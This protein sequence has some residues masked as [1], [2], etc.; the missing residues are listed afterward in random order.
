MRNSYRMS[1]E[2]KASNCDSRRCCCE[3]CF[4]LIRLNS[5]LSSD[6][7]QSLVLL[8]YPDS[9]C[10]FALASSSLSVG[11]DRTCTRAKGDGCHGFSTFLSGPE[12][13]R[14]SDLARRRPHKDATSGS[15]LVSCSIPA[16]D[17]R[18]KGWNSGGLER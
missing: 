5:L 13:R 3:I 9:T 10:T 12:A 1:A 8:R 7:L 11:R 2:L 14:S 6:Y 16:H 18:A 4:A 17:S 15:A